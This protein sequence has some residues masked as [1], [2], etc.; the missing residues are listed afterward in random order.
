LRWIFVSVK[1]K[2]ATFTLVDKAVSEKSNEVWRNLS[3]DL[4]QKMEL[5]S[6]ILSG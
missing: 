1:S 5:T 4:K 2:P 6:D 3:A